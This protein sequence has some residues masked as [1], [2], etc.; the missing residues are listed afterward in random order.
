[1]SNSFKILI[2]FAIVISDLLALV[3]MAPRLARKGQGAMIPV[4]GLSMLI[5][6]AV[7]GWVLFTMA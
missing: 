3:V 2:L 4:I 7:V 6:T 5:T 1:M